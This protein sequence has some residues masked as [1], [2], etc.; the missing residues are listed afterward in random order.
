MNF[1][2]CSIMIIFLFTQF[3]FLFTQFRFLFTQF[4]F[5]FTSEL[6]E[7]LYQLIKLR[8]IISRVYHFL[9]KYI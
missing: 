5:L 3:R 6:S 9:Y 7:L 1:F 4:R 8:L 2:Y